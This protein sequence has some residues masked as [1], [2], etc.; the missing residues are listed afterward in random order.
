VGIVCAGDVPTLAS[1]A[2]GFLLLAV[3]AAWWPTRR[4]LRL[5][6]TLALRTE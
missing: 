1:A 4:A 5:D 6:P 2:V 3:L